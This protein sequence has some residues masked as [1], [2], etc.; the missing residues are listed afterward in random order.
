M[1]QSRLDSFIEAWMNVFIGFSI[2]FVGNMLILPMFGFN[3][4]AGK[5]FGIGLVFTVISVARS[6]FIRRFFNGKAFAHKIG[7]KI[8]EWW[9]K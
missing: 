9:N 3:I 6:Y 2:N 5:A 8:K 4:T 7:L 1:E